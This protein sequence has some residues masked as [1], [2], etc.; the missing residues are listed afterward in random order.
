M[1]MK[2]SLLLLLSLLL[3]ASAFAQNTVLYTWTFPALGAHDAPIPVNVTY[4]NAVSLQNFMFG[5]QAQGVTPSTITSSVTATVTSI[6]VANIT[7]L[8]IGNGIC[9]SPSNTTCGIVASVTGTGPY[10]F[11]LSTGEIAQITA[12]TPGTAPAGTLTVVR[13]TI[14]TAAAYA[15]GQVVTFTQYGSNTLFGFSP[16]PNVWAQVIANP[17]YGSQAATTAAAAIAAAQVA[18]Q[19]AATTH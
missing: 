17:A 5:L 14:G 15:S 16:I 3:A 13:Q 10:T 18:L 8:T 2:K 19:T 11:V 1:K 9:F 12:I 4:N 6:P 7:G